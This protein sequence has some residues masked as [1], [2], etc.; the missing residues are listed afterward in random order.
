MIGKKNTKWLRHGEK[1]LLGI[2][3]AAGGNAYGAKDGKHQSLAVLRSF[4]NVKLNTVHDGTLAPDFDTLIP[5]VF[6]H[7]IS[8]NRTMHSGTCRD[9]ASHGYI[10]FIMDH[11]DGTASYCQTASGERPM[12]YDNSRECYDL[13]FRK[14]QLAIRTIEVI[15][16]IDQLHENN[17][18][19][20]TAKLGFP[21]SVSLDLSNLIVSGHS[22]GGG[23]VINSA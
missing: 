23:T 16:F 1:T 3:M 11:K 21:S 18:K 6:S 13:G 14:E 20:M 5:I 19:T 22:F 17:G 8:S 9:F 7:G 12:Y 15:A 10:V 2:A 4:R